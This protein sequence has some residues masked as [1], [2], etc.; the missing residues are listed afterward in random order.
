M[1]PIAISTRRFFWRASAVSLVATGFV[2]PY[3]NKMTR[4][5]SVGQPFFKSNFFGVKE[6]DACNIG[7]EEEKI[8][9]PKGV[10]MGYL[11]FLRS[12]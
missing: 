1:P 6:N 3:Q 2:A 9:S 8:N 5:G 12:G 4:S 7:S 11:I 10:K